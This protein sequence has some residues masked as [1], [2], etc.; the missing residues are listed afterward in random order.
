MSP[1]QLTPS[2]SFGNILQIIAMLLAVGVGWGV[3]DSRTS[4]LT[5]RNEQLRVAVSQ[6]D[7]RI[8]TLERQQARTEASTEQK[9]VAIL[10][11]VRR[12]EGRL[13]RAE[14]RTYP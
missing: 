4:A 3:M 2:V 8:R 14:D 5:E 6:M 13:D 12:I 9:F 1:P 7:E 10:E 11:A